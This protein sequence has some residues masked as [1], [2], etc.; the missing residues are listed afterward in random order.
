MP[1]GAAVNEH[2]NDDLQSEV[3]ALHA[4][5]RI[6]QREPWGT[7]RNGNMKATQTKQDQQPFSRKHRQPKI[8]CTETEDDDEIMEPINFSSSALIGTVSLLLFFP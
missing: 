1:R 2:N 8:Y 4:S 6:Q 5:T 7:S 3:E